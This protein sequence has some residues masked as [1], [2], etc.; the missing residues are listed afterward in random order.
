MHKSYILKYL[1][2]LLRITVI[3]NNHYFE[4]A[5]LIVQINLIATWHLVS[6]SFNRPLNKVKSTSESVFVCFQHTPK[7]GLTNYKC[8]KSIK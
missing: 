7:T 4:T 8:S 6:F 3:S 2:T 5:N 1:F